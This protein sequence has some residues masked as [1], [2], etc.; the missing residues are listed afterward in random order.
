V[1]Q[2]LLPGRMFKT[3]RIAEALG[4][5]PVASTAYPPTKLIATR[6]CLR[7]RA[8]CE[9]AGNFVLLEYPMTRSFRFSLRA[10]PET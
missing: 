5:Y 8:R 9:H 2:I 10:E 7:Q 4:Q 3:G 1:R 6:E